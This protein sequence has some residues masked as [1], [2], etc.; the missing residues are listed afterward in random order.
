MVD[1]IV[2]NGH[3]CLMVYFGD[4]HIT[5]FINWNGGNTEA[6]YCVSESWDTI[7]MIRSVAF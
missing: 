4:T 2:Y 6:E 7:W 3:S 1:Y 5:Y